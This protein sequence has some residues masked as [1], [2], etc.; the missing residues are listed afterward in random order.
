MRK[1]LS[2]KLKKIRDER[3]EKAKA[4]EQEKS[5]AIEGETQASESIR[6]DDQI[7]KGIPVPEEV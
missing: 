7:E 5:L 1:E 2:E 3:E 4:L 6:A